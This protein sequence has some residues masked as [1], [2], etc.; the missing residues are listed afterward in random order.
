VVARTCGTGIPE[1]EVGGW[2]SGVGWWP[3]QK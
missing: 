3:G 1:A 2:W